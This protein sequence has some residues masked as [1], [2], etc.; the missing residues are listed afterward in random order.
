MFLQ[1][2]QKKCEGGIP[3]SIRESD[4]KAMENLIS[5]I[6]IRHRFDPKKSFTENAMC[7]HKKI[8]RELQKRRVFILQFLVELPGTLIDA[9]LQTTHG[10]YSDRPTERTAKLMGYIGRTRDLGITNLAVPGIP[11]LY[12]DCRIENIIFIPPAVSYSHNIIGVCTFDGR[13]TVVG[14]GVVVE[15]L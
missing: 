10:C 5:G 12:E 6:R 2:H 4:N 11:V 3:V 13:M 8:K 15:G 7:V 1:R 9:V 14:H